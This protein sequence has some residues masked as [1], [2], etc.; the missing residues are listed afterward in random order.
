MKAL[1][2]NLKQEDGQIDSV[3]LESFPECHTFILL[4]SKEL[5]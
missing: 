3:P 4:L 2:I 1:K 5:S